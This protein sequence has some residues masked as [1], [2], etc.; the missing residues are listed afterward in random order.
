[1]SR[2]HFSRLLTNTALPF[3]LMTAG[4]V[5]LHAEVITVPAVPGSLD[6]ARGG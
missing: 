5:G 2:Q 3:A 4:A 1:M 6:R